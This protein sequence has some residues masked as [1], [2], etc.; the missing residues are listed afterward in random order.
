[1]TRNHV[2]LLNLNLIIKKKGFLTKRAY[3]QIYMYICVH[4]YPEL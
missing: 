3:I 4:M 2:A 1:M